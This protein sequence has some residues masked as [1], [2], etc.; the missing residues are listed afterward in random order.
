MGLSHTEASGDNSSD[1]SMGVEAGGRS[2]LRASV[3]KVATCREDH[4]DACGVAGL[5]H[6]AITLRSARLNDCADAGVH[7]MLRTIGEG[8]ERVGRHYRA[9]EL[10]LRRARLL[11]RDPHRV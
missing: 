1:R 5:D 11:D 4:R 10:T 2:M 6:L 7:G 9:V 3:A 8:E